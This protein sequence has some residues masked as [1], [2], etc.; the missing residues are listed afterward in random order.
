[1]NPECRRHG[2]V[3]RARFPFPRRAGVFQYAAMF[4]AAVAV[5]LMMLSSLCLP[6]EQAD[7]KLVL[8]VDATVSGPYAGQKSSDCLRVHSNG[9]VLYAR[10]WNSAATLIDA[11]GKRTRP[12]H[13]ISTE[14]QMDEFLISELTRL[15]KTKSVK[16]LRDAFGPPHAPIDYFENTSVQM[17]ASNGHSKQ[18]T[19]REYYV[20]SLDEKTKYPSALI[21][22]MDKIDEI[23]RLAE[24]KGK[25]V[26]VPADCHLKQ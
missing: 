12:E 6:Q 24:E 20:A 25:P 10:W 14:Y 13:T 23:Q 4:R 11:A 16:N 26:E 3:V 7:A 8:S 18:I 17:R 15:L 2:T 1:M 5:A 19:A 9:R 22:L 21:V